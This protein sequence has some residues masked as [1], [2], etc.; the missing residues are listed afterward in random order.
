MFRPF[1][2][3]VA[4]VNAAPVVVRRVVM[5]TF[6]I[7]EEQGEVILEVRFEHVEDLAA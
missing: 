7:R 1:F 2:L 6:G 5:K 4:F 3:V